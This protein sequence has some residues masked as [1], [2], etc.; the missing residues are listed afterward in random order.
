MMKL[1]D[2]FKKQGYSID[3]YKKML[4]HIQRWQEWWENYVPSF[5]RYNVPNGNKNISV[6]RYRMGMAKTISEAFADLLLNEKVQ[7]NIGKDGKQSA[8]F[9]DKFL[10][11]VNW[12]TISNRAMEL[13]NALGTSAIVESLKNVEYDPENDVADFSKSKPFA[14]YAT[15]EKIIVLSWI[16]ERIIDVAFVTEKQ[17]EKDTIVTISIHK[18]VNGEYEIHNHFFVKDKSGNLVPKAQEGIATIFKT[19]S[20]KPWFTI[21]KTNII[22]NIDKDSPY[23][24]SVYHNAVDQ[25][26]GVDIAYDSFVNEFNLGRKRLFIS[27]EATKVDAFGKPIFDNSD[28]VFYSLQGASYAGGDGTSE[29]KKLIVESNMELRIEEHEQ[30]INK[31]L[32]LLS[33]KVGLGEN[34]F[35]FENGVVKT[36]TEVISADSKLYRSIRKQQILIENSLYDFME[37]LIYIGDKFFN[38][39]FDNEISIDFD[40]SIIVDEAEIRRQSMLEMN[41]GV[42]API[43]YIIETRKMTEEQ[44]IKFYN[45]QVEW[46]SKGEDA[47]EE[48]GEV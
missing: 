45:K 37:T 33:T 47:E 38:E 3:A 12:E 39:K 14:E 5:H 20:N 43:Q 11:P 32:S 22:N 4:P 6:E 27:E 41:A 46:M 36:A 28:L 30:G 9:Y 29:P 15:A 19:G 7:Y 24:I 16:G 2:F 18:L 35:K 23:G 34:Y 31:A 25:L 1:D 13:T 26:K 21:I 17:E 8:D 42:I 44:A 10:K 48:G 40:D